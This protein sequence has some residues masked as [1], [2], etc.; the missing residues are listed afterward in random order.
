MADEI[1]R[2]LKVRKSKDARFKR[3]G[4]DKK[5]TISDSWRRPV[6][7]TANSANSGRQKVRIQPRVWKSACCQRY[8]PVWS[9]G[10]SCIQSE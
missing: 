3:E 8:A 6:V 2:L 10:S 1:R 7:C 9:E 4:V 5:K